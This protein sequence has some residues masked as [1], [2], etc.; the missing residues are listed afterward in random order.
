MRLG[1]QGQRLAIGER[2]DPG[3]ADE[4][5]T[6]ELGVD[7]FRAVPQLAE[8]GSDLGAVDGDRRP[9][10][11][12]GAV[13]APRL[14]ERLQFDVGGVAPEAEEVLA[15]RLELL[16]I[17]GQR[18]LG[19]DSGEAGAVQRPD[20]H[21]CC[22][23]G[24]VRP[25]MEDRIDVVPRPPL[26]HRIGDDP[27][28]Q[29]VDGRLV[30]TRRE[31]DAATGRRRRDRNV[32]VGRGLDD[33]VGGDIGDPRVQRDLDGVVVRR[34]VVPRRRL[35]QGVDEESGQGV[36]LVVVE[37]TLDEGDVAD[38]DRSW[39]VEVVSGGGG[40]DGRRSRVVTDRCDGQSRPGWHCSDPTT[41]VGVFPAIGA[42]R[43]GFSSS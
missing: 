28:Q 18:A 39:Q 11:L 37:L 42:P 13:L 5:R 19:I 21:H 9:E 8:Q 1:L 12:V 6:D 29:G 3:V 36:A 34:R 38:P 43:G 40:G 33:G 41:P 25:G 24:V 27:A 14:G 7:A 17:E 23:R 30:A 31:H 2:D 26:D 35:Q 10:R 20:R 15:D 32:Q 22:R 16:G 4:R